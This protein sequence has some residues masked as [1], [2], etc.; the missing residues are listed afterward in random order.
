MRSLLLSVILCL[1]SP[2]LAEVAPSDVPLDSGSSDVHQADTHPV[3]SSD[4]TWSG[5]MVIC[6]LG[7]FLA[8]MVVGPLVR[9]EMVDDAPAVSDHDSHAVD[10]H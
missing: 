6:I 4:A 1:S 7:L 2:V 3:I 8:A 5:S 10:H 9:A